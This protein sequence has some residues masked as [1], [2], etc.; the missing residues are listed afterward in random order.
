MP[1][2]SLVP[3]NLEDVKNGRLFS[4]FEVED[5]VPK[6]TT[7]RRIDNLKT[8]LVDAG[9][10]RKLAEKVVI[11]L[12]KDNR[13][14]LVGPRGIGKSTL[15]TYV[16]WRSLQGSLGNVTLDKPMD[17]VLRV[18][19]LNPG[20]ALTIN[21]LVEGDK[22]RFLV[23][24]DPSPI[25][26]YYKPEAMQVMKRASK[27][28]EKS[29]LKELIEGIKTTLKELDGVRNASIII[30]LPSEF[31]KQVQRDKFED[32]DLRLVLDDLERDVITVN[33]KDE[34]FLGE[35]IRKY[36]ECEDVS[37][38][39][40][41]RVI[42]FDTY[43]LVAKYVGIWLREKWCKIEDVDEALRKSTSKPKLFFAHYI[44]DI[45]LGGESMDL[46]KRVSV[47]LIL[48]A[49][50]G[51]IPERITY[52]SKIVNDGGVWKLIDRDE[53]AR[54][55]LEGLKEADLK[56]IARWLSMRHEDLIEET[57]KELVGLRGEEA[58]YN[59]KD[60]G[61]EGLIKI[62]DW[63]YEKVWG[64]VRRSSRGVR[65]EEV[66]T[67]LLIFVGE[68]LKYALNGRQRRMKGDDQQ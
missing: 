53:L 3:L 25:E 63:S 45:I 32:E 59:Y 18:D 68:R 55:K 27:N 64:E 12:V 57:L 33:L 21:N 6:I 2:R 62:L 10:F 14:V 58:R 52:I 9:K 31:Y 7:W 19:S 47:P 65:H 1:T 50:F 29:T 30:V 51:P 36:S 60:H 67:N 11:K 66:V 40:V 48:H 46:A 22:R 39:L 28:D 37:D 16:I 26:A 4:N 13:V 42:D 44:W 20:D 24:Y 41:E 23:I 38:D 15:A 8:D 61:F 5:G 34:G 17:T 43:T 56:P 49:T 54:S 35:V